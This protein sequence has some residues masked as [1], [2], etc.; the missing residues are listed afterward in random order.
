M[1]R[2]ILYFIGAGLS[3]ALER[4]P[5]RIP[6]MADFLAT[7]ADHLH[8]RV[9][10][11]GLAHFERQHALPWPLDLEV[12][13][14]ID[15][16]AGHITPDAPEVAEV[17]ALLK[18]LPAENIEALLSESPEMKMRVSFLINAISCEVGWDVNWTPLD[19]FLLRKLSEKDASHTFVSFNYDLLLD[20]RI[21]ELSPG[22]GLVWHPRDGYGFSA[23]QA[24]GS[25]DV[26][27]T[28]PKHSPRPSVKEATSQSSSL[29]DH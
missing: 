23:L 5:K 11:V 10:Q 24:R 17:A 8:N 7:M 9:V 12:R 22:L 25:E 2:H 20:R 28:V 6:L 27:D 16:V 18:R 3:K 19:Q 21:Q 15:K 13:Q 26:F 14:F 1:R 4:P 29:M